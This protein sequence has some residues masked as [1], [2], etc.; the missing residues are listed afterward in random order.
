MDPDGLG[1][2][3]GDTIIWPAGNHQLEPLQVL[4]LNPVLERM[5]KTLKIILP[6]RVMPQATTLIQCIDHNYRKFFKQNI[7]E[8]G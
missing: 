6:R 7:I 5:H 2:D 3:F 8:R 4:G 1:E